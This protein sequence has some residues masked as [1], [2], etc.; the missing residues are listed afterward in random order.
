[1]PAD[2][3]RAL[4]GELDLWEEPAGF[5]WRDDDAQAWTPALERLAAALDGVPFALAVIPAEAAAGLPGAILQ[6]GWRHSNHAGPAGKKAE[7]G[8][9]RPQ[10]TMLAE[11]EAGRE[12]LGALYG[13]RFLPV[14]APP[15]NRI[16]PA[17]AA[18]LPAAGWR[19]LSTF[20]PRRN[21][22]E[23]NAH[24]D[25]VAWR[26]HRGFR[27]EAG[28]LEDIAAHLRARRLGAADRSEPTGILS[29]HL[30]ADA[31]GFAFFRALARFVAAHPRARWR[32]PAAL[33]PA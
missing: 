2:P 15:W 25:P 18:R 28:V 32:D 7:F 26:T 6:H 27:G 1:M 20:R 16:D 13:R 14:L 31:Q 29:H 10:E 19:G 23:T 5:W 12:R 9:H 8:P 24:V 30:A 17:L 22:F 4:A 33:W 21:R 11:L 3:W